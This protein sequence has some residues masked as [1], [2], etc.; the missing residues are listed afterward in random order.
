MYRKFAPLSVVGGMAL[1]VAACSA[2]A[3]APTSA[4]AAAP[5]TAPAAKPTTA[6]ATTAPA[7]APTTAPA[8]KPTAAPTTAPAANPTKVSIMVGGIDKQIY[9][10][11]KLTEDLGYFKDEGLDVTLIDEP[12]G[13]SSETEVAAGNVDLG[14]GSYDHTIDLQAQ[15]KIITSVAQLLREPGEWVMVN[16]N[17]ASAIK[18][19]A[20]WLGVNAGVTSLGSGTHTL[21]RAMSTKAGLQVSDVNYVQAGAGDTFIAA[22]KQGRID[23]GITTQPTVLRLQNTGDAQVLVDLSKP[24][25]TQAALGGDYPFISLWARAD[26][27]AAHKDTVQHVV[28]AY[29][30]TMKWISTHSAQDIADKLPADYQAGDPSA[31]VKALSDSMGMFTPDGRM[32]QGGPEFVLKTLSS[33]DDALTGKQID[34]S[35]TWDPTFVDNALKQ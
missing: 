31:Y 15:G 28:N 5:T 35:K 4:P 16:K 7:A 20:D 19:P 21:M 11:N 29:V 8:A 1:V 33:F 34:L 6:P 2:P 24:D 27:I 14:S 9:L 13:V 12:S 30:K 17:K 10:P 22:M 32:P 18:S 25:T 3:A 26:Y 23:V